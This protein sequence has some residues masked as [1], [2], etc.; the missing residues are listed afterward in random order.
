MVFNHGVS[1]LLLVIYRFSIGG[2]ASS[3][4]I[5]KKI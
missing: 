4:L 1:N 5:Q 3:S 2:A